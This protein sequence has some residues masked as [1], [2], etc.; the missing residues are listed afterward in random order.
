MTTKRG[1]T[2]KKTL[3]YS[4][5]YGVQKATVLPTY[6][7][8]W[9]W[10][11]LYNEQNEAMGDV[12]T[13]FTPEMIQ[14]MKDG[15]RPDLFANTRW[16]D[17]IFVGRIKYFVLLLYRHIICLCRVEMQLLIIWGR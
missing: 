1:H 2:D 6:I 11:T 9:D 4:G 13:N 8:S 3:S 7:N 14:Q 15:S 17:K 5:S 16:S 12:T 10:A